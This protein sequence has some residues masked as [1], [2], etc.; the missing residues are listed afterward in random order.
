MAIVQLPYSG[1]VW[2]IDSVRAFGEKKF[3]KLIDQPIDCL[4][5]V[6]IWMILVWRVMDDSPNSS[7]FPPT[8][9]SC[10]TVPYLETLTSLK[11]GKF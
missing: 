6:L 1:K 8:K 11:F 5:L 7:N 4:L 3:G 10:Y 9:L 2:R